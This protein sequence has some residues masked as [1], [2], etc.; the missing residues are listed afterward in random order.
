M[1]I[2]VRPPR[3]GR[4]GNGELNRTVLPQADLT[5][6]F[7]TK[8]VDDVLDQDQQEG[9]NGLRRRL[10][11]VDLVGFGVGVVIG[12][13][14]FTLTG[15]EAKQHAGPAIVVS[16]VLAGIVSLLA[17]MCYAEL[18]SAVPTVVAV[19]GIKESASRTLTER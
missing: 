2:V 7:R 16:F 12:T 19:V 9:D 15:V 6:I 5:T 8:S 10:G 13:G 4:V 3:R 17:A 14:I 11:S 18:A 1:W